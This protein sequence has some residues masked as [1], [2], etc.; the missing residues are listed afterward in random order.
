MFNDHRPK[1]PMVVWGAVLALLLIL[2]SRGGLGLGNPALRQRFV[3]RP[4]DPAAAPATGALPQF[5]WAQLPAGAR[6]LARDI[7]RRLDQG[8]AAPALTPQAVAQGGRLQVEISEVRPK[9]DGVQVLGRVTNI[10]A[11]PL[12]V[13][14]SAFQLRDSTGATYASTT[15]RSTRL[16]PGATTPLDLSVPLPAGRGLSLVVHLPPDPPLEQVILAAQ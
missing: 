10:G 8:Q 5:D 7:Q 13:P 16:A 4:T 14:V 2:L 9:G 15:S 6:E 3:P 12:D 1:V 11:T